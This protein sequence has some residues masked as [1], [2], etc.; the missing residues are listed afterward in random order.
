[1]VIGAG[2][3]MQLN[4]MPCLDAI[5]SSKEQLLHNR[6]PNGQRVIGVTVSKAEPLLSIS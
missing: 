1:M 4:F 2:S 5:S 3:L 6:H